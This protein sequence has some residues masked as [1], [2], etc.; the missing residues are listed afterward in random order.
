MPG[1]IDQEGTTGLAYTTGTGLQFESRIGTSGLI[2]NPGESDAG[3]VLMQDSG[4]ILLQDG[5]SFI[6]LET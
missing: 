2:V 3:Y 1:L 5:I 6:L 4:Y